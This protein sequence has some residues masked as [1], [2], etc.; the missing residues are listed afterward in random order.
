MD[1]PNPRPDNTP[2][3]DESDLTTTAEVLTAREIL[4]ELGEETTLIH[5][6]EPLPRLAGWWQQLLAWV[7]LK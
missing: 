6:V 2:S 7:G 3:T 5:R 4:K 1:A